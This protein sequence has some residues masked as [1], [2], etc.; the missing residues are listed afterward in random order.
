AAAGEDHL[1]RVLVGER[2]VLHLD[3]E[4][5]EAGIRGRAIHVRVGREHSAADDL[6]ALGELHLGGVVEL[7][8]RDHLLCLR[9]ADAEQESRAPEKQTNHLRP[10]EFLFFIGGILSHLARAVSS[11]TITAKRILKAAH[12][13]GT[14][15][16]TA[17]RS[18][19]SWPA[20]SP[21]PKPRGANR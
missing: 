9:R 15:C 16:S 18:A 8:R 19:R 2:A 11:A 1:R 21:P 6:L 10:P 5:I 14:P 17:A 20:R 7:D 3:P 12:P 13:G 4:E